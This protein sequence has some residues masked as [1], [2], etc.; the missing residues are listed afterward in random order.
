MITLSFMFTN[1]H[2]PR[3]TV[4]AVANCENA[5]TPVA[6]SG[7]AAAGPG[8]SQPYSGPAEVINQNRNVSVVNGTLNDLLLGY[9]TAAYRY[10]PVAWGH[11]DSA[12]A[13]NLI[14]NPS[15]VWTTP[16]F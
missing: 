13:P 8:S 9:G 15:Y 11:N 7:L 10:P 3:Y 5:P 12:T 16:T 1:T 4:V 2:A 6:L 14:L